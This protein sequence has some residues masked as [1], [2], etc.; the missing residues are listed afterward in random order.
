MITPVLETKNFII[1]AF[2]RKDLEVFAE[3][4]SQEMVAKYQ[5]WANYTFQDANELFESMDYSSCGTE[6]NW[7][8]LA[9][10]TRESD[11]DRFYCIA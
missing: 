7:Y 10:S 5:S 3:Y 8:Q 1:R 2:E 11:R 6:G 4:R 9:I